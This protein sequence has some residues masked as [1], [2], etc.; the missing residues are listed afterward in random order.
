MSVSDKSRRRCLK[1]IGGILEFLEKDKYDP[2]QLR[3]LEARFLSP[4][5]I[6]EANVHELRKEGL[7]ES[8]AQLLALIPSL[9]RYCLRMNYGEHP[10]LTTLP[11]AAQYLK[12]L[13]IG[14]PIEQFYLLCL[15]SSG[16]LIECL[17]L[18]KGTIDETPFYL[19]HLL[20]ALV[21]AGADAIVLCH[22]H[23]GGTPRP[24]Q[25]DVRCTLDALRALHALGVVMLDHVIIAGTQTVS[26]RENGFIPAVIWD[27]QDSESRL[28]C[29]WLDGSES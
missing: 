29:H 20:Q 9:T 21:T 28:L 18:Q 17:L 24:S 3:R 25:A 7:A 16:R 6:V 19:G 26:L 4:S 1:A 12:S 10:K 14:I 22:N 23:P 13:Y 8:S 5:G 15:D 27:Q 11:T 2:D